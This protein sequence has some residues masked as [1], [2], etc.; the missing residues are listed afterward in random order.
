MLSDLHFVIVEAF[1]ARIRTFPYFNHLI[2]IFYFRKVLEF[3]KTI[4]KKGQQ[5][6]D[7]ICWILY[8]TKKSTL[9]MQVQKISFNVQLIS[10]FS[11]IRDRAILEG[12]GGIIGG[13]VLF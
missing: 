6:F 1:P 11:Q 12:G 13:A 2:T 5:I 9:L 4:Q 10:V 8:K 3:A 7:D